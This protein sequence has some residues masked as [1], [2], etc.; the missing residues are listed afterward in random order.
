MKKVLIAIFSLAAIVFLSFLIFLHTTFS[1]DTPDD[2][3][4][5]YLFEEF[6]QTEFPKSGKVKE[7]HYEYGLNDGI[8]AAI[9]EIGSESDFDRLKHEVYHKDFLSKYSLKPGRGY[10]HSSLIN[11][12]MV[13]DTVISND[14]ERFIL[15]FAK[16]KN[17]MI[18]EKSY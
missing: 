3:R 15:A 10:F 16:D 2:E 5:I 4:F 6:T 7:K 14:N 12:R 17:L 11:R 1:V 8:E 18:I 13:I 9:F